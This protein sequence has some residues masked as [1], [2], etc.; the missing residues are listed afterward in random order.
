[1][2]VEVYLVKVGMTMTEGV[3]EQWYIEDGATVEQGQLLYALETEK[4]N[5]DVDAEATGVVRH[6]V[7]A[8]VTCE[9]GDVVGYIYLPGEA[10]PDVVGAGGGG[11]AAAAAPAA[12]EVEEAQA[13]EAVAAAPTD[14]SGRIF[15][16]P[17]ARRVARERNVDITLV[18]GSG[19]GGR[20]IEADV[21]AA[22]ARMPADD[23]V[24]S[25]PAA[26][27][28]ARELGVALHQASGTGPGG[29]VTRQDIIDAA[30]AAK[31]APAPVATARP[32]AAAPAPA[33]AAAAKPAAA[34]APASNVPAERVRLTAMRKTI[35]ARMHDSLQS[36]AQL[37]MDMDVRMDECV[38]LR[39]QLGAEWK[40]EGIKPSYT[41]LVIRAAAK[42]LREHPLM[43][44][45][46][47][48][49]E[50]LLMQEVH[51]GMAVALDTGL[52]VP[53][54]RHADNLSVKALAVETSRLAVAARD[55]QLGMDDF[56]GG[57]FTV[58]A[59]GMFGVDSFTPIINA[60]QAGI[61]GVN[62]IYDGLGWDG[63]RPVKQ[64][65]MRLSLTWDHRVLDGAPAAQF[66]NTVKDLL[67]APFRLLI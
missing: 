6:A 12:A 27:R 54:V 23:D 56:S 43:N 33:P 26:R 8:G 13:E 49:G 45:Q 15:S 10:I 39:E 51:V 22:A 20:I 18:T 53:V 58:T 32:A 34:A 3:I 28:L 47:G 30:E 42:A 24:R 5:L 57:T 67:E 29:R 7:A 36:M 38:K 35:S 31:R 52:V 16:S 1:M 65:Q 46:M 17:A 66:L 62:R 63:D 21:L 40:K 19:P 9:P 25:S 64:K 61:L 4:V 44:A 48:D 14:P 41:D 59:L 2:P 50:M 55:G 60:P 37:T 11:D